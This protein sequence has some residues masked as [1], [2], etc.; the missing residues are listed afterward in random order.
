[1]SKVVFEAL[2][3]RDKRRYRVWYGAISEGGGTSLTSDQAYDSL[4]RAIR[5]AEQLRKKNYDVRV[6]DEAP[7]WPPP[8]RPDPEAFETVAQQAKGAKR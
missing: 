5:A 2:A 6:T 4:P 1:M 3:D 7:D 8:H